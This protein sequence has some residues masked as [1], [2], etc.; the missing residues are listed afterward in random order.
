MSFYGNISN[1]SRTQFRFERTY[2]NRT[3]M[4][5]SAAMDGVYV[6]NY[7]LVDYDTEL[8]SDWCFPCYAYSHVNTN[9]YTEHPINNEQMFNT[10][11]E[12]L[13]IFDNNEF[14]KVGEE[15]TYQTDTTYYIY[16][17]EDNEIDNSIEL[18]TG[19]K[20]VVGS[21]R[22]TYNETIVSKVLYPNAKAD[23]NYFKYFLVKGNQ[24]TTS[25][26]GMAA[27][28][29]YN[30]LHGED[31]VL[32]D[33]I[34]EVV[35]HI[36]KNADS[37]SDPDGWWPQ[38]RAIVEDNHPYA[39]NFV[40]DQNNYDTARGYDSTVWQKTYSGSPAQPR[41]VM[42][43]ELNSVVPSFSVSADAP[44]VSPTVPHFDLASTNFHYNLH[45]QSSWGFRVKS[46]LNIASKDIVM[47][48]LAQQ[49]NTTT[50][51]NFNPI[52][53]KGL[54]SDEQISW[55]RP[56]YD[57]NLGT[58]DYYT[59]NWQGTSADGLTLSGSWQL[60]RMFNDTFPGA[61]YYNKAGFDPLISTHDTEARDQILVEPSGLSGQK[62]HVHSTNYVVINR[63][64][65]HDDTS[66]QLYLKDLRKLCDDQFLPDQITVADPVHPG[67]TMTKDL[68]GRDQI[69]KIENTKY[70]VATAYEN[71]MEYYRKI[72][73]YAPNTVAPQVDTQELSITLP[74]IGNS[75][76]SMWDLIYG[77]NV[78]N[79]G[80]RRNT[81]LDWING[82][83]Y[84]RGA[85]LRL[86]PMKDEGPGYD[87]DA[88]N[89]LAG[90]INSAHDLLGMLIR[91]RPINATITTDNAAENETNLKIMSNA[92]VYYYPTDFKYTRRGTTYEW[93]THDVVTYNPINKFSSTYLKPVD[94]QSIQAWPQPNTSLYYKEECEGWEEQRG[95][96]TFRKFNYVLDQKYNRGLDYVTLDTT[97]AANHTTTVGEVFSPELYF[98]YD[99]NHRVSYYTYDENNNEIEHPVYMNSF[100]L[101]T[102]T[103]PNSEHHYYVLGDVEEDIPPQVA[104]GDEYRFFTVDATDIT[105][106]YYIVPNNGWKKVTEPDPNDTTG[107]PQQVDLTEATYNANPEK[108]Y[109]KIS[110]NEYVHSDEGYIDGISYYIPNNFIQ[111]ENLAEFHAAQSNGVTWFFAV[112]A[113]RSAG[114]DIYIQQTTYI[115]YD[116]G[117][118]TESNFQTYQ[119]YIKTNTGYIMANT[120]E[121]NTVYYRKYT[122]FG[123]TKVI[124]EISA[125][126]ATAFKLL[127]PTATIAGLPKYYYYNPVGPSGAAEYYGV[128]SLDTAN[129][130]GLNIVTLNA[131]EKT[132]FYVPGQY[133]Y[134]I[135]TGE[136]AGSWVLEVSQTPVDGRQYYTNWFNDSINYPNSNNTTDTAVTIKYYDPDE[137]YDAPDD[138]N[139]NTIFLDPTDNKYKTYSPLFVYSDSTN[140]FLPGTKW[141]MNVP[142]Q[143]NSGIVLR[144]F[145]E[146]PKMIELHNFGRNVHTVIGGIRRIDEILSWGDSKT[147]SRKTVQGV[148]NNML[149]IIDVF[150]DVKPNEVYMS[151]KYGQLYTRG[152]ILNNANDTDNN[153]IAHVANDNRDPWV[154]LTENR[155][156]DQSNW[157]IQ[158]HHKKVKGTATSGSLQT[159]NNYSDY[160]ITDAQTPNFG[161]TF[162]I[163]NH[164]RVDEAGHVHEVGSTTVTI[165]LP[166]LTEKSSWTNP[167]TA[168]VMTDI[169]LVASTGA[170]TYYKQNVGTLLLTQYN[171]TYTHASDK[172]NDTDQTVAATDSINTAIA[173]LEY[174]VGAKTVE[175]RLGALDLATQFVDTTS[176]NNQYITNLTQ[177]D[178]QISYDVTTLLNTNTEIT[179]SAN[180]A[181]SGKGVRNVIDNLN[182]SYS[183]TA[184]D[185]EY[186]T[187]ISIGSGLILESN[188]T[189]SVTGKNTFVSSMTRESTSKVAP[190]TAAVASLIDTLFDDMV[191]ENSA[192]VTKYITNLTQGDNGKISYSTTN[193][194]TTNAQ[195]TSSATAAVSGKGVRDAITTAIES[196]DSSTSSAEGY[197]TNLVIT[198]GKIDSS[199]NTKTTWTKFVT[200]L[201][202]SGSSNST[203]P[204]TSQAILNY[205]SNSYTGCSS[206]TT[207]GTITNGTWQG[208]TIAVS[209][210]GTGTSTKPKQYGIIYADTTTSYASTDA[211]ST[212][213]QYLKSTA[214][215]A[216]EWATFSKST[217]GLGNVEN[218]AQVPK[219]IFKKSY[220]L[221]Y[222]D[223][224]TD[225][226]AQVL[227]V[228][229]ANITAT[230]KFLSMTGDGSVGAAPIWEALTLDDIG[231]TVDDITSKVKPGSSPEANF[232]NT[233][234]EVTTEYQLSS[235]DTI[236]EVLR[237]M[238]QHIEW[239]ESRVYTLENPS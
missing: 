89:T 153:T 46:A 48:G 155:A 91:K 230:K 164:M 64:D 58:L 111:I 117:Y 85:G 65:I 101:T 54:P 63:A 157:H 189:G 113:Q 2:P 61:I 20:N 196:L 212:A 201:T 33:T 124:P 226:S 28:V 217:V 60:G 136:Y 123:L 236:I 30:H 94:N 208:T 134:Q 21:K 145:N 235:N 42:L 67:E 173:K 184:N 228:L 239:L 96:F 53:T 70:I 105:R 12:L 146:V 115:K 158:V 180:G 110:D 76:A 148:I 156:A 68:Y 10:N 233:F 82:S 162:D 163:N 150:K 57:E 205:L 128:T 129:R 92:Y 1:I 107:N 97:E 71:G 73:E 192:G 35:G 167:E 174:K 121:I 183:I 18:W 209:K 140:T 191:T 160:S 172:K 225:A 152:I 90:S 118:I 202:A 133:Y 100:V 179:S 84:Y 37:I 25:E 154:N 40:I 197:L 210:G 166:S 125:E 74:S 17:N 109:I 206:I 149:D 227:E 47:D 44:T 127:D 187:G 31:G 194:L 45:L 135:E 120:F 204:P 27:T 114:K 77:D 9:H 87:V 207:V 99:A 16:V 218:T 224:G 15:D 52:I 175:A 126:N 51:L 62:Y 23:G 102:D 142:L 171:N 5:A 55:L 49:T 199:D 86:I 108:Y 104:F 34:F 26:S 178:G 232:T 186:I 4:D 81:E 138:F 69:Y 168:Q 211:A 132:G 24:V 83:S 181:V 72:T 98:Q 161:A 78:V 220:Q 198:D 106:N 229:D 214:N 50:R 29:I 80:S 112:N 238:Y 38:V 165:P 177:A 56:F 237:R 59:Y 234:N 176:T 8:S 182:S 122:V 215:G 141:N 13:Y 131:S 221:L 137:W 185:G 169:S 75:I 116:D 188:V 222:S 7:V 6:G 200:D 11:K 193:L 195:I 79:H 203:S 36:A 151:N 143:A 213:G 103:T 88:V 119:P 32:K 223:N 22:I 170:L 39:R 41:Y 19:P 159:A 190:Q 144:Q 231:V 216:P 95:N 14:V 93:D 147:R 66:F 43:A 3:V 139:Q 130:F 219:N